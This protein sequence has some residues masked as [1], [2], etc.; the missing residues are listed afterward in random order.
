MC[1]EFYYN[2]FD[3]T[4]QLNLYSNPPGMSIT[5]LKD[6]VI[7]TFFNKG[8]EVEQFTIT[9]STEHCSCGK[10]AWIIRFQ[11]R[12]FMVKFANEKCKFKSYVLYCFIII[13]VNG[14]VS[15]CKT[16]NHFCLLSKITRYR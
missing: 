6:N 7:L 4:I 2:L 1:V 10:L 13:L 3:Y 12:T 14:H 11:E 8:T 16:S 9:H 5:S 15:S